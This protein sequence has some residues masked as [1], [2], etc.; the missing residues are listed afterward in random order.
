MESNLPATPAQRKLV[1][2]PLGADMF[3]DDIL[4]FEHG[5]L[6][7]LEAAVEAAG[8]F[9]YADVHDALGGA[10]KKDRPT[11]PL[12]EERGLRAGRESAVR[13]AC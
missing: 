2:A 3:G 9:A 8:G 1:F 13:R 11:P 4:L 6:F 7:A 5:I 12:T 10:D